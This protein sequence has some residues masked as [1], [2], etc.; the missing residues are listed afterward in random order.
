MDRLIPRMIEENINTE[1]LNYAALVA[2]YYEFGSLAHIKMTEIYNYEGQNVNIGSLVSRLRTNYHKGKLSPK[3]IDTLNK[4]GIKWEYDKFESIRAYYNDF[5]SLEYVKEYTTYTYNGKVLK[6]GALL[7]R[8]R[9]LYKKG[10]LD[11][12]DITILE[13]MGMLWEYNRLMPII[14]YYNEFG[15]LKDI[16]YKTTYVYN[17]KVVKIGELLKSLK[18]DKKSG[19][20]SQQYIDKL[21]S[22]N[23]VWEVKTRFPNQFEP[24]IAYYNEFGSLANIEKPTTYRYNNKI[25]NIGEQIA[26]LRTLYR[27]NKLDLETIAFLESMG[28][29]WKKNV[30]F[31]DKLDPVRAYYNEFG[32]LDDI[33]QDTIYEYCGQKVKIG[34]L[35]QNLRR[36]SRKSKLTTKEIEELNSMGMVWEFAKSKNK[37]EIYKNITLV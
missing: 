5:G 35:L 16:N 37:K 28:M 7:S 30:R 23:I 2:Y 27:K 33:K 13:S 15:T 36:P 6:L 17:G 4:M 20:L 29:I 31:K 19:R 9:I 22:M 11:D 26:R 34:T 18:V 24:I 14:A 1:K 21:D 3:L 12:E 10:E 25:V 32:S 8:Y